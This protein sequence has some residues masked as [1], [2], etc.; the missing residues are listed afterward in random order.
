LRDNAV[1]ES[2]NATIKA[3]LIYRKKRQTREEARAAMYNWIETWYTPK[4][5]HSKL[6]YRSP[7]DFENEEKRSAA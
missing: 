1:A 7:G 3:E 6:G 2:L 4:R 5:L